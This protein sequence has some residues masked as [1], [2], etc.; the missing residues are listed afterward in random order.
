MLPVK[1]RSIYLPPGGCEYH[2]PHLG[3]QMD[4]REGHKSK[5]G[6]MLMMC[7]C[8]MLAYRALQ[9]SCSSHPHMLLNPNL[10]FTLSFPYVISTTL[11]HKHVNQASSI[12]V[13]KMSRFPND[14]SSL[15]DFL[16]LIY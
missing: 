7:L 9:I 16:V 11:A 14:T 8:C 3:V 1:S 10:E 4:P 15:I 12:A 6:Q 13:Y 2:N 5:I